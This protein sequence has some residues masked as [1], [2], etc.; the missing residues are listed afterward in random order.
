[1]Q[2]EEHDLIKYTILAYIYLILSEFRAPK[3][4]PFIPHD[5]FFV[6]EILSEKATN[7][8]HINHD[9]DKQV[10]FYLNFFGKSYEHGT[11]RTR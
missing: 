11:Y 4:A 2:A 1:M 8:G 7:T 5:K 6:K 3:M 10:I 9:H